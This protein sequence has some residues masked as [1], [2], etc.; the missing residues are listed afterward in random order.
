MIKSTH[1]NVSKRISSL[2][3]TIPNASFGRVAEG[4]GVC[5]E[6]KRNCVNGLAARITDTAYHHI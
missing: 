4:R 1:I 3:S 6:R 2:G 5:N